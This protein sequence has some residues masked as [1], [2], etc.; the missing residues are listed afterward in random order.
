MNSKKPIYV[1]LS[2]DDPR[3]RLPGNYAT[4]LLL[5][6]GQMGAMLW[7]T[8]FLLG[9]VGI[10][11]YGLL[12]LAIQV[13][14]YAGVLF[15]A[16]NGSGRRLLTL[17]IQNGKVDQAAGAVGTTVALNAAIAVLLFPV[18]LVLV[19]NAQRFFSIPAG[20]AGSAVYLFSSGFVWILVGA[21]GNSFLAVLAAHNRLDLTKLLS[22]AN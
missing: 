8:P 1:P 7:M 5:T 19:F 6:L 21:F 13:S 9:R 14:G 12:Q 4:S 3:R 20:L 17:L 10:E 16:L 15:I 18:Y 22:L 2:A 11:A